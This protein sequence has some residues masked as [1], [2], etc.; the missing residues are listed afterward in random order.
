[1]AEF[2]LRS[3][4]LYVGR[5]QSVGVNICE[6]PS[7]RFP[8]FFL[9]NR[10]PSKLTIPHKQPTLTLPVVS[11][12]LCC[13]VVTTIHNL[14]SYDRVRRGREPPRRRQR[15]EAVDRRRRGEH[16]PMGRETRLV[17]RRAGAPE[18]GHPG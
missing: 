18:G 11:G 1:M 2:F 7:L 13:C 8:Q 16:G 9:L 12:V 4:R 6:C 5:Y 10:S 15:V 3:C 17:R 14:G